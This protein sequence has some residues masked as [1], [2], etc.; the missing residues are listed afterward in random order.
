MTK[1]T[2][3]L[4]LYF[5]CSIGYAQDDFPF[6]PADGEL[7]VVSWN[8]E[9]LGSRS[10]RRS[11]ADLILLADRINSFE[12]PIIA[13]QEVSA[14][15]AQA[16][17]DLI[18]ERLGPDWRAE[19]GNTNGFIFNSRTVEL[20]GS[21]EL[22]QL[23]LPPY[24]SFYTDFPNWENDFGRNGDPFTNGNSLPMSAEFR[25][26]GVGS[27]LPILLVSAHFHAG[28]SF[29]VQREYEGRAIQLW[30]DE[31]SQLNDANSRAYLLGDFNAQPGS[32]PHTELS[33]QRL[34]KENVT[35]TVI[36]ST[37]GAEL[38]HIYASAE[39]YHFVSRGTA[40]VVQPGHYGET[41]TQFELIYSDHAPILMDLNLAAS[42]AYSGSW[43]D[44]EHTG[45]GQ[46]IQVLSANR[47]LMNWYTYDEQGA[48]MWL[49]GVGILSGSTATIE[50]MYITEGGI[51]GP[52][53]DP[54]LVELEIWGSLIMN[55][56]SCNAASI[57]YESILGFGS[58]TLNPVRLT[59]VE[60]LDCPS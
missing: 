46:I 7:R 26:T 8:I 9:N 49:T 43:Y 14:N 50:H 1:F 34:E 25:L 60:G 21:E 30:L 48:Q 33:L 17:L 27:A 55:F 5:I 18:L 6:S 56:E 22:D 11:D 24:S 58:G 44:P 28:S 40:F 52:E 42:L 16:T 47:I 20:L 10:P 51:F 15:R 39:G 54:Q 53:F 41:P 38:D 31:I 12:S 37:N 13:V 23:Q 59:Q 35:S 3:F 2:L 4:T 57:E 45:E 19:L 32:A 36:V 29:A